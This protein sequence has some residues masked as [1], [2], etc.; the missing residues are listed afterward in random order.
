MRF[1]LH[2]ST[3]ALGALSVLAASAA[4]AHHGFGGRYDRSTPV[5]LEG[6]VEDAFFGYP[7]AEIV[8]RA[9]RDPDLG[10]LPVTAS[11]FDA[12]LAVYEGDDTVEI[13]FPPVQLFFALEGRIDVGDRIAVIVLRNCEPPHQLRGQWVRLADGEQVLRRGTMQEEVL[14]C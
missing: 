4:L 11:E 8:L 2:V 14:G 7:H 12:G 1:F 5:W 3:A 6:V 13:E 9:D 10:D